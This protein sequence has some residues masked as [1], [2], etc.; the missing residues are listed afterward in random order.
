MNQFKHKSGKLF[1]EHIKLEDIADAVGTPAYVYSK[2]MLLDSFTELDSAFSGIDHKVFYSMKANSN[3]NIARILYNAGAG[4]DCNSGGEVYR[5]LKAGADPKRIILAGVGKTEEDIRF[6]L[7]SN[8]L[9]FKVES[10]S[11]M[12][13]INQIAGELGKIAPIGIRI[14]PDV[15]PQTHPYISTGLSENKFGIDSSLAFDAFNLVKSLPNLKA[16]GIDTHIGSQ[17]T[18]IEP[19]VETAMRMAVLT[20]ELKRAGFEI[21]HLDIGGGL[22]IRYNKEK[23]ITPKQFAAAVIPKLQIT[24]CQI[25]IEPGRFI[26][27]NAGILLTKVIYTKKHK[28]KNFFIVD[29]GMNDLI[30]P[31]LYDAYHHIQ[32]VN[33]KNEGSV[34]ADIV[35]PVCESGDF[36]GKNREICKLVQ[37]DLL[38]VMSAGAYGYVMS[39]NYNARPRIPEVIVSGGQFYVVTERET[40][41]DLVRKEKLIDE[42]I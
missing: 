27:G 40:Y 14:N 19:F 31:A 33:L 39:S 41:E 20:L 11:E 30:R 5:A 18:N 12:R 34:V 8:I 4:L 10:R 15:D 22:G 24:D 17:I 6:A 35:G 2:K 42:L 1:C 7:E 16:V 32:C 36:F 13:K 25:I 9:M 23:P 28:E 3:L 38:A 21:Q 37:D 29:A 26:S